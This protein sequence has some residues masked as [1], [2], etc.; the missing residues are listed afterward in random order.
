MLWLSRIHDEDRPKLAG[1]EPAPEGRRGRTHRH[2]VP[3]SSPA[4][5]GDVA[6][7]LRVPGPARAERRRPADRGHRGHHREETPRGTPAAAQRGPGAGE[8]HAPGRGEASP[9]PGAHRRQERGHTAAAGAGR[10]GGRHGFHGPA[11]RRDRY[12]QGAV[13]ELHPRLQPAPEPAHDRGQLLGHP[14]AAPGERAVRARE[15]RVHRRAVQAGRPL[16]AR[17]R[18][19]ALPRRGRRTAG[20]SPGQAPPGAREPHHRAARKPETDCHRRAHRRRHASRPGGGRP[21]RPLPGRPLLPPERLSDRRSRRCAS[22]GRT[23]LRW[24]GRSSRS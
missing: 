14:D 9:H 19:D 13:R 5:R 16:R 4:A 2:G 21:R 20:G 7:A 17:P 12:R 10:A 18:L 11:P 6:A 22:A 24:S 15:G 3:L 1:R 8:R 23:S